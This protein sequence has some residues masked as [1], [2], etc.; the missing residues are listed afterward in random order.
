MTRK[1]TVYASVTI[2]NTGR[3][4]GDE[5]VQ[6][7]IHEDV[8]SLVR[9]DKEL[10]GFYRISLEPGASETVRFPIS[11]RSLEFWKD[12]HWTTESGIFTVMVGR[13]SENPGSVHL[14]LK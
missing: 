13:S 5:I 2:T 9:P 12:G 4:K 3:V 6:L 1:D 10:K 7:Y 11:A 8:C 14:E